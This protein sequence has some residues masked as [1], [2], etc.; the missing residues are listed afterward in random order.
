MAAGV[1][2]EPADGTR[3]QLKRLE[4]TAASSIQR[5]P[6]G[7]VKIGHVEVDPKRRA[8]RA[9]G[10]VNMREGMVEVLACTPY[11]KTHE[12]VLVLNAQPLHFQLGLLLLGFR[13][14]RNPAV[15][16]EN[17]RRP[18]GDQVEVWIEW[19][20]DGKPV[21]VRAESLVQNVTTDRPMANTGWVFLGSRIHEGKLVADLEGNIITTYH[22]P[23]AILE[24]PLPSVVNDELLTANAAVVPP[25]GTAVR[26]TVLKMK[27][28]ARETK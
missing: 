27:R 22:D 8:L 3:A 9:D 24:N 11:G 6:D 5:L 2:S 7:R 19:Q 16:A 13:A 4:Q 20:R 15:K 1:L 26:L 21:K 17:D 12:S 23:F 10:R 18:E 14:G 28:N 25:V